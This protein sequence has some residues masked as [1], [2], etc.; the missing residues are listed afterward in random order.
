MVRR[1]YWISRIES[2]WK[3]R[4]LVWLSGVRRS[5]KTM[6]CRSL[7]KVEYFDCEL[8]RVRRQMGDPEGFLGSLKGQRIAL[9]EIHRLDNPSELLK[10]AADHFPET[11]LVATG[12]ST[13]G[14][15]AKFKDTLAG[16]KRDI[17]LSPMILEDWEAFENLG[18][19][20]R[21]IRG[22]LPSF[23]LA[24]EYPE[25]DYQEWMD[26]YWAKDIQE[27]FRVERRASF[28]RFFELLIQQSGGMFEAS[29]LASPV[30]VSRPT[31]SNYLQILQET[32]VFFV[33]KPF[34]KYK[35]KE[36]ISAPKVYCFDT[37]FVAYQR[38]WSEIREEDRGPLWEHFVLNQLCAHGWKDQ[39]RYW[40]DKQKR[41]VDFV[42]LRRGKPPC[43]IETKWKADPR[44]TGNLKTFHNSY[45]EAEKVILAHDVERSFSRKYE[46]MQV[47]FMSLSA[48]INWLQGDR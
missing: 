36:I 32:Y 46:E 18:W 6:L 45:P 33:L 12:S 21:F 25:K 13:L 5:G 23:Y 24:E 14:A 30:G 8:P 31:L 37:G 26:A 1:E 43:A 48:F 35:T 17:W 4:S 16:R 27:L 3:E 2:A 20:H 15:S 22:G 42:L 38:G 39:L 9:D 28:F 41:E 10:I 11:K 44:D 34:F 29:S 7:E 19:D 47:R 40:R